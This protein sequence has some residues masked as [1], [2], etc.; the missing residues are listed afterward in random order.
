MARSFFKDNLATR[1]SEKK[2]PA[3]RAVQ[4]APQAPSAAEEA[5]PAELPVIYDDVSVCRVLRLHR[6]V[7]AAAR[8]KAARGKVWDAVGLHVGMTKGW[9]LD[10]A[11]EHGIVPNFAEGA[12]KQILP[13]DGVVSVRLVGTHPN[14]CRCTVE[15]VATGEREFCT[16]RN[17]Y[18][19]PIH[20]LE[21]FDAKRVEMNLEWMACLNACRY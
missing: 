2:Q 19:F 17:L 15:I 10:Y 9:V 20:Y 5:P 11:A 3:A 14:P 16:V 1:V 18:Q 21:A 6:R 12:L 4:E 7:L 8:T 13:G